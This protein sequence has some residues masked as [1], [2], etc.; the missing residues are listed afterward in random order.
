MMC[1]CCVIFIRKAILL[2]IHV[3]L[4][5]NFEKIFHR[6]LVFFEPNIISLLPPPPPPQKKF[7]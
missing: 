5:Q 1:L 4:I 2:Q 3:F 6:I 7:G